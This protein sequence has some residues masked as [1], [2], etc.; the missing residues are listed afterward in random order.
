MH[1]AGFA[2]ACV[3]CLL[4]IG[5]DSLSL[6]PP[7]PQLVCGPSRPRLCARPR[8]VFETRTVRTRLVL[9]DTG[10]DENHRGRVE[11]RLD[12]NYRNGLDVAVWPSCSVGGLFQQLAECYAEHPAI[13]AAR[14]E[15]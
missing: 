10:G 14:A 2:T 12:D 1:A 9:A 11:V 6:P 4:L 8:T 3:F 5:Q 15:G 13:A 7:S